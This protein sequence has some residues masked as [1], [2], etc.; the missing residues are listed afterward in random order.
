MT[1]TKKLLRTKIEAELAMGKTPKELSDKYEVGYQTILNWKKKLNDK[2]GDADLEVL[3][4]VDEKT[5]HQVAA[6]IKEDAPDEVSKKIDKLV[7]GVTALQQLE[8]KFNAIVL[9]LLKKAEDFANKEDLTVTQWKMIGDGI[10]N[11]YSN[12][13]NKSG[14]NVNVMNQT[15]ISGEKLSLFKASMK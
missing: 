3:L 11:L 4:E 7:D 1:E 13:F 8:P 14:I 12:I 9:T 6:T 10:S 15:N 2:S 5:L